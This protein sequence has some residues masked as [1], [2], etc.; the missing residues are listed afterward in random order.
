M[1]KKSFLLFL[2]VIFLTGCNEKSSIS[3]QTF[4]NNTLSEDTK[5]LKIKQPALELSINKIDS[6]G[7]IKGFEEPG[8]VDTRWSWN[9]LEDFVIRVRFAEKEKFYNKDLK[10]IILD[11]SNKEIW[12]KI[13]KIDVQTK[14]YIDF[15]I[16][17]GLVG[18]KGIFTV[19]AEI[20]DQS[21]SL[22]ITKEHNALCGE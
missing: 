2:I 3:S 10:I 18:C 6:S 13:Q 12:Q 5:P 4:H 19:K 8:E 20:L 11:N 21:P 14:E 17:N 1:L 16:S 9:Y 15:P 7:T 22:F